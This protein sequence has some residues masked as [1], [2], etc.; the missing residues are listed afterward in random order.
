M[1]SPRITD[2]GSFFWCDVCDHAYMADDWNEDA[3]Q[4]VS[5]AKVTEGE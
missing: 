3:R 5:C 1:M 2:Y 4:C